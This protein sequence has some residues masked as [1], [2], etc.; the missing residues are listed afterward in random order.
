VTWNPYS[1]G[2]YTH[3]DGLYVSGGTLYYAYRD[4]VYASHADYNIQAIG[5]ATPGMRVQIDMFGS[6]VR[7]CGPT[8]GAWKTVPAFTGFPTFTASGSAVFDF[9]RSTLGYGTS[10]P[11]GSES[12]TY[13][14]A[15]GECV[16]PTGTQGNSTTTTTTSVPLTGV[17]TACIVRGANTAAG[18]AVYTVSLKAT[19]ATSGGVYE[20]VVPSGHVPVPLPPDP[21]TYRYTKT[22]VNGEIVWQY[23]L[24]APR[25]VYRAQLFAAG[26]TT[27]ISIVEVK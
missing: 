11:S 9:Q 7:T 20:L 19:G 10:G 3:Y 6:R 16:T 1:V 24:N 22:A 17:F 8:A 26:G 25:G 12:Y 4:Y 2:A 5:P 21:A 13:S 27:P 18:V 23:T 15:A 14:N